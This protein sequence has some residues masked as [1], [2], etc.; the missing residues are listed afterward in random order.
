MTAATL[1]PIL[2]FT[3]GIKIGTATCADGWTSYFGLKS[4][5]V[6]I[7]TVM[8]DDDCIVTADI[9][10]GLATIKMTDDAGARVFADT[11]VSYLA[12]GTI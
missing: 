10:S 12:V 8:N 4:V 11:A 3:P 1:T 9:A 5:K 2:T 7:I 6:V